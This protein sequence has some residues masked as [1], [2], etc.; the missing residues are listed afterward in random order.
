MD[1][2]QVLALWLHTL[3]FV[4]AW[5]YYGVLARIILPGLE[6][7]LDRSSRVSAVVA[8]E[9][10]ALPLIVL[11]LVLFAVTGAYL[12]VVDPH[13]AGLGNFMASTWTRL[14]MAKHVLV[15]GLV[16]LAV[17]VDWLIRR[18]ADAED[19]ETGVSTVRLAGLAAEGVTALGALIALLTVAAQASA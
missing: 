15:V 4:I 18:A 16:A 17:L 3:A 10:Q 9:R 1:A 13:Y 11:T 8:I 2:L 5:G 7:S 12:L 6:R 14:M 19:D